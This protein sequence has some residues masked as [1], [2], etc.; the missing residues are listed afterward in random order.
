MTAR[1]GCVRA[2]RNGGGAPRGNREAQCTESQTFLMDGAR[3]LLLASWDASLGKWPESGGFCRSGGTAASETHQRSLPT[4]FPASPLPPSTT[5]VL[6]S[7]QKAA[8]RR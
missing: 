6:K 1:D 5:H 7:S 2:A 8:D 4:F 3:A